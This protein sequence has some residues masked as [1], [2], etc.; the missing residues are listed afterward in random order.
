MLFN[1]KKSQSPS[2]CSA[3]LTGACRGR[4]EE[5]LLDFEINNIK[6]TL[7]YRSWFRLVAPG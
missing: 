2:N 4:C 7:G 3:A 5:A 6:T 1:T